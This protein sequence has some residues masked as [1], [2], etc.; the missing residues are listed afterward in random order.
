MVTMSFSVSA[1][2]GG[3]AVLVSVFVL[4]CSTQP[5]ERRTRHI[6]IKSIPFMDRIDALLEF[7]IFH[8]THGVEDLAV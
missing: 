4:F 5:A 7:S 2:A 8:S 1:V 3:A 6:K